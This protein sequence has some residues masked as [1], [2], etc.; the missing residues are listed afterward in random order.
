MERSEPSCSRAH[1]TIACYKRAGCRC[2]PCKAA[3]AAYQ[4]ALRRRKLE[5]RP[6]LGSHVDAK[7]AWRWIAALRVE[8]YTNSRIAQ[9]LGLKAPE[10]QLHTERITLKNLLK[11]HRLYRLLVREDGPS[12]PP[13]R[14]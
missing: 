7:P 2:T 14:E 8:R 11:V 6:I 1:G 5:G 12:L 4:A 9:L 10:L 3:N 13:V